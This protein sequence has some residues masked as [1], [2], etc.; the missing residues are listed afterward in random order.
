MK[1]TIIY[2]GILILFI[3]MMGSASAIIN[4]TN[5]TDQPWNTTFKAFTDLF[6]D[7]FYLIPLAFIGG[8]IFVLT[9]DPALTSAYFMMVGILLTFYVGIFNNAPGAIMLFGG[10]TIVSFAAFVLSVFYGTGGR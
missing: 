7:V 1:K 10:I 3:A 6:G 9:R 8:G 4:G 2:L 5:F